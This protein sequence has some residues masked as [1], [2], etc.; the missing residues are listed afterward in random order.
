MH[1]QL[2]S[3]LFNDKSQYILLFGFNHLESFFLSLKCKC[4]LTHSLTQALLTWFFL[5][6][7]WTACKLLPR[8]VCMA[9]GSRSWTHAW[10]GYSE[11]VKGRMHPQKPCIS[12]TVLTTLSCHSLGTCLFSPLDSEPSRGRNEVCLVHHCNSRIIEAQG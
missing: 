6:Y 1:L 10:R 11:Q 7:C 8:S 4:V 9:S 3:S 12:T 5:M 2:L